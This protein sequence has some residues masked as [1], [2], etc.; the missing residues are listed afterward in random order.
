MRDMFNTAVEKY[1]RASCLTLTESLLLKLPRKLRDIIYN[2]TVEALPLDL[3][4]YRSLRECRISAPTWDPWESFAGTRER[5][6]LTNPEFIAPGVLPELLHTVAHRHAVA[7]PRSDWPLKVHWMQRYLPIYLR[8]IDLT[9]PIDCWFRDIH[10]EVNIGSFSKLWQLPTPKR[11][12]SRT[13]LFR[14]QI[15]TMLVEILVR[16]G[17]TLTLRVLNQRTAAEDAFLIWLLRPDLL[18]LKERG[19]T[20]INLHGD[21]NNS[22][23]SEFPGSRSESD[24]TS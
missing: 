11:L 21:M 8:Y 7:A 6:H 13:L 14:T 5:S 3:T 16:Q 12:T 10:A 15:T 22:L 19:F 18:M 4:C 23:F 2:Y 24:G 1:A 20:A 9:P 17:R